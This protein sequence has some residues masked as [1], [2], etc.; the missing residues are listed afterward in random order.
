MKLNRREFLTVSAVTGVAGAVAPAAQAFTL[1]DPPQKARLRLSCQEGLTPGKSLAEKL[2]FLEANG[3]EGL[4]LGGRG[5]AGRVEELQKALAARKIKVSAI[6]AGFEGVLISEQETVRQKALDS[7]KEILTAAGALKSTGMIMVP[8]FHNQT[9]LGHQESRELLVKLL[10]T[11]GDHAQQAGTRVLLEPLNRRECHFLRQVADAAAICRD[12]NNPG[13]GVMG[14][15]WHMTWE[16]TSDMA[17][18]LAAGK[19][20]HHVHIASRK[21]RK[22]PGEDDGDNY[23]DGFK[24]L[25]LIGYQGFVSFECGCK[26]DPVK[27]IPAAAKLLREQWELANG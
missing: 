12:V 11:L 18:F 13:V 4:E 26:G 15:F 9:K 14:D 20:L 6:C 7:M 10:A 21:D 2:D 24:G 23:V 25:K 27:A 19:Y 5:L 22:V 17:A 16:E 3:F 1:P 8:A